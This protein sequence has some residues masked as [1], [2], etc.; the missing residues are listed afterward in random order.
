MLRKLSLVGKLLDH[1]K[2][3]F[4]LPNNIKKSLCVL[5]SEENLKLLKE[6][7]IKKKKEEEE[8]AQRCELQQRKKEKRN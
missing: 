8:K 1:R 4:K 6:K 5:T 7:E 3:E 2:E